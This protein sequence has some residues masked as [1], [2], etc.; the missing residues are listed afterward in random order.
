MAKR[1]TDKELLALP[2]IAL[3]D[4]QI[5]RRNALKAKAAY[6]PKPRKVTFRPKRAKRVPIHRPGEDA[7]YTDAELLTLMPSMLSTEQRQRRRQLVMRRQANER[8]VAN[9]KSTGKPRANMEGL[10]TGRRI[11]GRKYCVEIK[12]NGEPCGMFQMYGT[13]HCRWHLTD[14]EKAAAG[15]APDPSGAPG[16]YT[17]TP[18][19]GARTILT[20]QQQYRRVAEIAFAHMINKKLAIFGL[21]LVGY[22]PH[23]EPILEEVEG[24]G[25]KL[26]GE[27]KDGDIIMTAWEDLVTMDKVFE[28]MQD[29]IFGKARQALQIEGGKKPIEVKPVRSGERAREVAGLLDQYGI[30]PRGAGASAE[31][32]EGRRR[33]R[34]A[35]KTKAETP[36]E[37]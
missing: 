5:K 3:S 14:D 16:T 1:L 11:P 8:R 9:K 35:A 25:V 24:G 22:D 30:I 17:R 13:E 18:L 37:S 34:G 27:S 12:A 31:P 36:E 32:H 33:T 20:P 26:H 6:K 28:G 7:E 15:L 23:G 4:E 29:R 21:T 19:L 2:P 10:G